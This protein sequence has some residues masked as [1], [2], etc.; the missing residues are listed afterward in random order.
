MAATI[1]ASF[2]IPEARTACVSWLQNQT[3]DVVAD[4]LDLAE[5][6]YNAL[7]REVS[8]TEVVQLNDEIADLRREIVKK[9]NDAYEAVRRAVSEARDQWMSTHGEDVS[10][11]REEAMSL[12][13]KLQEKDT[14][15]AEAIRAAVAQ[16][17]ATLTSSHEEEI[18]KLSETT[19]LL[20]LQIQT[21]DSEKS[22]A[23]SSA[24][25]EARSSLQRIHEDEI[26]TMKRAHA[27]STESLNQSLQA[28]LRD[29][30]QRE[31]NE[32]LAL[33][34]VKAQGQEQ[35]LIQ[36]KFYEAKAEEYLQERARY[37]RRLQDQEEHCRKQYQWLQDK[38]D[39][40]TAEKA[41]IHIEAEQTKARLTAEVEQTRARL[42]DEQKDFMQSLRG[43]SSSIGRI[44]ENIVTQ[45]VAQM[46]LGT[47]EDTHSCPD[48]GVADGIWRLEPTITT[49]ASSSSTS[50]GGGG[51]IRLCAL[52]ETKNVS[53]LNS[54]KDIGKFW[55]D[56]TAALRQDTINAAVFI[57]LRARIPNSRQID[58]SWYKGIPVLQ[59][60]R[61]SDDSLPAA[62]L[63]ELA[64][65]ALASAWPM[66]N[67]AADRE[68]NK[69]VVLEAVVK[70]FE[71][72][73][74]ELE[75]LS[76]KIE[77][78][79]RAG[80][81]LR[82]DAVALTKI[83]QSMVDG[84]NQLR[85][86]FPCLVPEPIVDA[87]DAS[88]DDDA[89]TEETLIDTLCA[90]RAAKGRF[91]P[92][93][94]AYK[95]SEF[96][97]LACAELIDRKPNTFEA[98]KEKAKKLSQKRFKPA[99]ASSAEGGGLTEEPVADYSDTSPLAQAQ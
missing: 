86:Q 15:S 29:V 72:Q 24:V 18:R 81:A 43:T 70:H 10:K 41:Q 5:A 21:K 45:V 40:I 96:A 3:P 98:A 69:D 39:K 34:E 66:I 42:M 36:Q 53:T 94:A 97:T 7:Q 88:E 11:L 74:M 19:A 37:E 89:G 23:I 52:V 77:S 65:S 83:R 91:P 60:S 78:I 14:E 87:F 57:S 76:K 73:M 71:S 35:L 32:R 67:R 20:R 59:A 1:T 55:D 68:E 99:E 9:D 31:T 64:F 13:R 28:A 62:V 16:V 58:L 17:R 27:T 79:D 47:W 80:I 82:R 93:S 6:C 4:V 8:Q 12:H 48:Q 25:L 85:L 26:A 44:G 54:K 30:T 50:N 46:N 51:G 90:F 95:K 84:V 75:K 22:D 56:V 49:T 61:S 33:A 92:T 2:E 38:V 63:V